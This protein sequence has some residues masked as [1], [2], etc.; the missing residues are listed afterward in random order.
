M[1]MN[2]LTSLSIAIHDAY[3][4]IMRADVQATI[5]GHHKNDMS[6]SPKTR[7]KGVWISNLADKQS[8]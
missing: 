7:E 4:I 8:P 1:I 5:F 6:T 3:C 2:H